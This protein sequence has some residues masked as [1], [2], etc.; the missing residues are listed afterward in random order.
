MVLGKLQPGQV[1][2]AQ[3]PPE[4]EAGLEVVAKIMEGHMWTKT[5]VGF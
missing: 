1:H 5:S 2:G 3:V 4:K